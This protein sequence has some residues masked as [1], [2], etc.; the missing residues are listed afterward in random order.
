MGDERFPYCRSLPA[1]RLLVHWQRICQSERTTEQQSLPRLLV[2]FRFNNGTT[3]RA[4]GGATLKPVNK[5]LKGFLVLDISERVLF[6]REPR[7]RTPFPLSSL[8]RVI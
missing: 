1:S 3:L 8:H 5:K 6:P 7:R 4:C 2:S